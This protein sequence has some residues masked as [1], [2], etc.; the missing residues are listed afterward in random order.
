MRTSRLFD[1]ELSEGWRLMPLLDPDGSAE[2]A[3]V[4]DFGAM[5]IENLK[6]FSEIKW[7]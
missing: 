2:C 3:L 5:L 1:S 4:V 6:M 7:T